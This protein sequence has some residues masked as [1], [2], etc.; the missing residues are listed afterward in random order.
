MP[1]FKTYSKYRGIMF[2]LSTETMFWYSK[3]LFYGGVFLYLENMHFP[4]LPWHDITAI[5]LSD[6]HSDIMD[7]G[8]Q[9]SM[10]WS[11]AAERHSTVLRFALVAILDG[12]PAVGVAY[13]AIWRLCRIHI[14]K[15]QGTTKQTSLVI[16]NLGF[17]VFF[18]SRMNEDR[19]DKWRERLPSHVQT[20][21]H[22]RTTRGQMNCLLS[23][24]SVNKCFSH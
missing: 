7:G 24:W 6:R 15:R 4:T 5:Y 10:R 22:R 1:L 8:N 17:G 16:Y 19:Q 18:S 11:D 20:I 23:M 14:R 21:F 12:K 2:S 9:S 13:H 3:K